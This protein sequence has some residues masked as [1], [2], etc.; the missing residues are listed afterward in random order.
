M[1]NSVESTRAGEVA[2]LGEPQRLAEQ[3]GSPEGAA[4]FCASPAPLPLE[5]HDRAG[6]RAFLLRYQAEVLAR[7]ELP[8][9]AQ[10]FQHAARYELAELIALD[11]QLAANPFLHEF[12][13]ASRAAG[14]AQLRRLRPLRDQRL[15]RR[16]LEA[17][18]HGQAHGWHTL[19]YGLVLA[20]F[21]VPLRQGLVNYGRQTLRSLIG[22]AGRRLELSEAE[23][24]VLL[25]EVTAGLPGSIEATLAGRTAPR[26]LVV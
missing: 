3:L 1:F 8:A 11:Q 26:L 21:S 13:A 5:V 25:E 24:R 9:I 15:L 6:L 23:S 14:R 12:A 19:V 18:E 17:V 22:S 4:G 7:I 2:L 16:Y 20:L 10:A